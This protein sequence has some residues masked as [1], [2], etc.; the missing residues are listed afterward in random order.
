M[1][2]VMS[3]S[4]TRKHYTTSFLNSWHMSPATRLP[5]VTSPI[6]ISRSGDTMTRSLYRE[7]VD[8]QTQQYCYLVY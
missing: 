7:Q 1:V 5:R 8:K 3:N 4:V 2:M 6:I